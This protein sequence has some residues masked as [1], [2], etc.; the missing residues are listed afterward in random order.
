MY[1]YRV[2]ENPSAT[3]FV[4]GCPGILSGYII[5]VIAFRFTWST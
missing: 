2:V 4:L 5:D 3:Q 1:F